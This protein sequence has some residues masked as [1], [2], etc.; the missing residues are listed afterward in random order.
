[1]HRFRAPA[2]KNVPALR[3]QVLLARKARY[4]HTFTSSAA[5]PQ[6]LLARQLAQPRTLSQRFPVARARTGG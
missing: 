1:M 6:A 4:L 5:R 2:K 3:S